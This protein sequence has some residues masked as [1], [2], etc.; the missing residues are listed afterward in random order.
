MKVLHLLSGE[1]TGGAARGAYWLHKAQIKIGIDSQ[2]F[3]DSNTNYNETNIHS[4]IKNKDKVFRLIRPRLDKI[5][6]RLFNQQ[7]SLYSYNII[8]KDIINTEL[9]K[10]A[11]IIHLHWINNGFLSLSQIN[12]INKPIVW[13][14]RDMWPFTG[15]CHYSMTCKRYQVGC[16]NCPYLKGDF[17]YDSSFFINKY[18]RK[19]AERKN[20]TVVGISSWISQCARESAIFKNS[21]VET[22]GNTIDTD[23]FKPSNKELAKKILGLENTK[24]ISFGAQFI[25]DNYKGM[26]ELLVALKIAYKKGSFHLLVFGHIDVSI[27]KELNIPYT[28]FGFIQDNLSLNLI[29]SASDVF[30]APSKMEAFG[31]TIAESMSCGTP[32][33]AFDYSGPQ[34]IITHYQSGYLAKPY[35]VEDLAYGIVYILSLDK[36]KYALMSKKSRDRVINL[37]SPEIT[38]KMYK[39]L[40]NEILCNSESL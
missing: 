12:K 21:R 5:P 33:V 24:I 9:Y 2:L 17:L 1:L 10:N 28:Y 14:L 36:E 8:G 35:M 29:Y 13:T 18:K 6:N 30:V 25:S 7:S 11:D 34:D 23:T 22:I 37:F 32:V 26:D 38:A 27:L 3:I 20:I 15:G 31:K 16:G 19:L 39:T 4:N 40:Y